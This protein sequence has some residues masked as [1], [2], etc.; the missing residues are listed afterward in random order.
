MEYISENKV[1]TDFVYVIQKLERDD[2]TGSSHA[3]PTNTLWNDSTA[4]DYRRAETSLKGLFINYQE[5]G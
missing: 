2:L 4:I 5:V 1:A 3:A